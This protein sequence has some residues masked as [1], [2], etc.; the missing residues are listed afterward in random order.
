MRAHPNPERR[1]AHVIAELKRRKLPSDYPLTPHRSGQWRARINGKDYYFGTL[2]DPDAA[3]EQFEYDAPFIEQGLPIPDPTKADRTTLAGV[4]DRWLDYQRG[5]MEAD[6]IAAKTY[7]DYRRVAEFMRDRLGDATPVELLTPERWTTLRSDIDS[8]TT[9]PTVASRYVTI[10]KMPFRWAWDSAI[11]QNPVRFGPA[12]KVANKAAM[13]KARHKAQAR[14]FT[15]SEIHKLIDAASVNMRAMLLLGINCGMTQAEVAGLQWSDINTKLKR[16]DTLRNKTG[17]KRVAPLW[18][19]TLKALKEVPRRDDTDRIFTTRHGNP[20]ISDYI[21]KDG[22]VYPRDNVSREFNRTADV[23]KLQLA[24]RLGFGK[25]RHTFRTVA[26]ASR[27]ANAI[28]RIMGH[29]VGSG[30]VE[31]TYIDDI[32]HKRLKDVTD[33]VRAWFIKGKK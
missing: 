8:I 33:H 30:A 25:L 18:P 3:R 4:L 32:E 27:D 5:R 10:A 28:K 7:D 14:T 16:L 6:G 21:S 29:E 13:R 9:S 31:A 11:I 20:Y 17:V 2:D 22:K 26:D 15:A 1:P 12:F 23:A 19:E 24:D